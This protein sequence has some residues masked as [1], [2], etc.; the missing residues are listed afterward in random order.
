LFKVEWPENSD[1]WAK[2]VADALWPG[3]DRSIDNAT[4]M[5]V[6][7]DDDVRAILAYHNWDEKAGVIELSA[8]SNGRWLSRRIL[9]EM[10]NYPF[11]FLHCQLLVQRNSEKNEH[12]NRQLRRFGFNEYRIHRARG[13]DEDELVFTFTAEQWHN[14]PM[15]LHDGRQIKRTEGTRS[16]EGRSGTDWYKRRDEHC[17]REPWFGKP[18][19]SFDEPDLR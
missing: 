10:Y 5:L 13:R 11:E 9:H 14:H 7:D 1:Q 17:E 8:V 15:R 18:D 19:R 16:D 4:C 12:L 2:H 3:E 6:I